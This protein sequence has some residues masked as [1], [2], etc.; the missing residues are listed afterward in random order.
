MLVL[1]LIGDVVDVAVV[2]DGE[3]F[4]GVGRSGGGDYLFFM[5]LVNKSCVCCR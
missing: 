2:D 4:G 5:L 1:L 3:V